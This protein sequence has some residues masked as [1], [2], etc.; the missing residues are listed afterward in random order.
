MEWQKSQKIKKINRLYG[1]LGLSGKTA[2]AWRPLVACG[3]VI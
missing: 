1:N 3:S 2:R